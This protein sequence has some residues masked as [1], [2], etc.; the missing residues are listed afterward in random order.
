M[1][2]ALCCTLSSPCYSTLCP[3]AGHNSMSSAMP[4]SPGGLAGCLLCVPLPSLPNPG[5][6]T[7]P[8]A[9]INPAAQ[10]VYTVVHTQ[11]PGGFP[12]AGAITGAA[13]RRCDCR[14]SSRGESG[15]KQERVCE[16]EASAEHSV[17]TVEWLC[18]DCISTGCHLTEMCVLLSNMCFDLHK[19]EVLNP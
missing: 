17:L 11:H 5:E 9:L 19:K 10:C 8:C 6:S 12:P 13:H 1:R 3:A 15:R 2:F 14:A 7:R 16:H 4:P 18:G